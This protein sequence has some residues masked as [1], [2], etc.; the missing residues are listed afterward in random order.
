MVR[1]IWRFEPD[2][3]LRFAAQMPFWFSIQQ[4]STYARL[5]ILT[6]LREIGHG[7]RFGRLLRHDFP[8]CIGFINDAAQPLARAKLISK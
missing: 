6:D 2:A 4:R 5:V 7:L 1:R 3:V 8:I